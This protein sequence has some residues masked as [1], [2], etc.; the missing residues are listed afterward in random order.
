M[1]CVLNFE[2]LGLPKYQSSALAVLHAEKQATALTISQKG[3]IPY[4]KVYEVLA[5]LQ[6]N[7][8]VSSSLDRPK[9]YKL[10]KIDFILEKLVERHRD[11]YF[12][13]KKQARQMMKAVA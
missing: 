6:M 11:N 12:E 9:K 8:F 4:T 7:G 3:L 5:S 13:A 10:K 1:D 2:K